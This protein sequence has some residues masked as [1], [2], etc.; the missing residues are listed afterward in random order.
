MHWFHPQL[1]DKQWVSPS[2]P[3]LDEEVGDLVEVVRLLDEHDK[4]LLFATRLFHLTFEYF[5]C[6]SL[7]GIRVI[8]SLLDSQRESALCVSPGEF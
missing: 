5:F 3:L 7:S 8:E 6:R 4:F 2:L 1:F